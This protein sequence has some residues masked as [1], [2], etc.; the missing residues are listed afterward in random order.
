MV[1]PLSLI[2]ISLILLDVEAARF[3][4]LISVFNLLGIIVGSLIV[5][6]LLKF[7]RVEKKVEI[8]AEESERE[9]K[10]KKKKKDQK[11]SKA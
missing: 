8:E 5:F 7:Y 2:G 4:F 9:Q 1:P 10:I 11:N 6:S 3:Y